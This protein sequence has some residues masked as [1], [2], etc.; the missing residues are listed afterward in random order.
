LI[1]HQLI[2]CNLY[3]L[4]ILDY[5]YIPQPAHD[6]LYNLDYLHIP[7]DHLDYRYIQTIQYIPQPARD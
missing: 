1:P 4:D 2:R 5:L 3:V 7:L 6:Y